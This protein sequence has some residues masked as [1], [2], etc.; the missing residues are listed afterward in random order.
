MECIPQ[1]VDGVDVRLASILL[2]MNI[3]MAAFFCVVLIKKI[4]E[5]RRPS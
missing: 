5:Q 2:G 1:F 3:T 4:I